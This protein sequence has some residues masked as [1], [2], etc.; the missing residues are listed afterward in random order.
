VSGFS[1][2]YSVDWHATEAMIAGGDAWYSVLGGLFPKPCL[3]ILAAIAAGDVVE[4][5]RLN[6]RLQP[7]WDLFTTFSSLRVMYA[8]ANLVGICEAELPRPILRLPEA[9]SQRIAKVLSALG[10]T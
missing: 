2:G 3:T 7:M 10:L 9:A 6:A 5:R 8:A 1:L 4:A